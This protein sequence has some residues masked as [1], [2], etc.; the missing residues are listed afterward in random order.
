MAARSLARCAGDA[1]DLFDEGRAVFVAPV[2]LLRLRGAFGM[3][4]LAPGA[5]DQFRTFSPLSV[6]DGE[7]G[8]QPNNPGNA[9]LEPE[10]T[11]EIEGGFDLGMW[12]GRLSL[13]GTVYYSKTTDAILPVPLP[14]SQGFTVSRKAN[15]G[16]LQNKGWE[17]KFDVLPIEG[18]NF[19]WNS[20]V[21]MSGNKNKILE[22]GPSAECNEDRSECR[23]GGFRQ[24]V[25]MGARYNRTLVG[26][27][28]ATN[29]HTRSDTTEYIGDPLPSW[30]G[31]FIN[32]FEFLN[33]F[34]LYF[35]FTWEKG[36]WF[37][38][39][40]RPYQARQG[41]G[42]EYLSLIADDGTP[43]AAGDSLLDFFTLFGSTD[44]RDNIR[45][46]EVSLSYNIPASFTGKLGLGPSSLTFSGQ[47]LMWWDDCNCRD[48]NGSWRAGAE[49]QTGEGNLN[50]G[51]SDFLSNPQP[52]RF[53]FTIRTAF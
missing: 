19:R 51:N 33:G 40:D 16:E 36:A 2:N 48:P 3:S 23:L 18:D 5:F 8:V 11:Q 14:P 41:A 13:E 20:T 42:D 22:L 35:Q 37:G 50:F 31:S 45:F 30:E 39:G 17:A 6:L 32:S 28:A 52:R 4:G 9:D 25:A 7:N 10:K 12:G 43:T 49:S 46:G 47:N 26:Y 34:R 44:K 38:N 27:D 24:N 1:A 15:V 21:V 53:V 29:T